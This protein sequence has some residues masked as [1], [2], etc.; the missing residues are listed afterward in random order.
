M[1][2]SEYE[3]NHFSE[4]VNN[5]SVGFDYKL[6]EGKFKNRIAIRILE[7]NEYPK[8]LL[9]EAMETSEEL[10]KTYLTKKHK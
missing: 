2:S 5:K 7:I 3:L 1:L 6:K 8:D 4:S 10:D 9:T